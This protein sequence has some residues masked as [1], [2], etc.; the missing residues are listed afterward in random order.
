M[1]EGIVDANS[2]QVLSFQ[3][4]NDYLQAVGHVYP[5]SNDKKDDKGSLQPDWPMP[6]MKVG[7]VTT[8]SGGNYELGGSQTARLTGTYVEMRDQCSTESGSYGIASLISSGGID[9]GGSA[10]TD[11]VTPG[12]GTAAN[13]HSSRSG[14][15]EVRTMFILRITPSTEHVLSLTSFVHPTKYPVKQNHRDWPKPL[16][17]QHM[18]E[19]QADIQHEHQLKLQRFF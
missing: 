6:F 19:E 12:F 5:F 11:C 17:K 18:A 13:T 15:Y 10:G 7:S 4:T 9:W 16:A 8:D 14:F 1:M 2:G 3:D